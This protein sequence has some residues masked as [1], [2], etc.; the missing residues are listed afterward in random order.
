MQNL[1]DKN[2]NTVLT[3]CNDFFASQGI[4]IIGEGYKEIATNKALFESYVDQLTE[5]A[6]SAD[7]AAVMAQLMANTNANILRESSMTGIQ[8]IASLSMPVIRKLWPKF[9]LKEALPTEVAK[10]PR[11]VVSYTAPYMFKGDEKV[12]I[13]RNRSRGARV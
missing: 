8:P 11:F 3:E 1:N 6:T 7:D 9:A 12:Y 5:G 4:S 2:F 10:T 13:P